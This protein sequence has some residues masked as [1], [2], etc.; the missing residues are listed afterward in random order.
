MKRWDKRENIKVVSGWV[1][2]RVLQIG[3][4]VMLISGGFFVINIFINKKEINNKI[5]IKY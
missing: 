4:A 2:S 5:N 1:S 3:R